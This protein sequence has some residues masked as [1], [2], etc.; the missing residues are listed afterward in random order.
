VKRDDYWMGFVRGLQQNT[1]M[2]TTTC[3]TSFTTFI[4][5][6]N[7]LLAF[8]LVAAATAAANVGLSANLA[9]Y[10]VKYGKRIQEAIIVFFNFYT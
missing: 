5:N 8:D 10:Y 1:N 6:K 2:L 3:Y 4:D 7:E 9:S